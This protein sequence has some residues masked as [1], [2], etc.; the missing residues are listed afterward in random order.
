LTRGKKLFD[1]F[2]TEFH[3]TA[4]KILSKIKNIEY[5]FN[6]NVIKIEKK[7]I[8]FNLNTKGKE[9]ENELFIE[10]D[11]VVICSG[12]KTNTD[13]FTNMMTDSLDDYGYV[14]VNRHFQ[15]KNSINMKTIEEFKDELIKNQIIQDEKFIEDQ[16]VTE[17]LYQTGD[18]EEDNKNEKDVFE[19]FYSLQNKSDSFTEA[20]DDFY[21]NIFAIGD[22]VSNKEEKL[23]LYAQNHGKHVSEMIKSLEF[24]KKKVSPYSSMSVFQVFEIGESGFISANSKIK[25]K[26]NLVSKV[27]KMFTKTK[28]EEFINIKN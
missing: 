8:Y 12:F 27:K 1:R 21:E 24:E 3:I 16:E 6:R 5:F 20:N 4:F 2:P 22:I 11:C 15:V 9:N 25:F 26:G 17:D 10:T 23:A 28:I 19:V 18:I 13:M 7:K 14:L